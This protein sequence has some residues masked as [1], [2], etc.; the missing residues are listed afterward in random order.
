[1]DAGLLLRSR[2]GAAEA[3]DHVGVLGE[4]GPGLLAVDDPLVALALSLGLERGEVGTGAGLRKA[5]APPV[6]D[7]GNARQIFLL[8]LLIAEGVD[9][10]ADHADAEGERRRRRI[11]LQLL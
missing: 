9:H 11:G 2:I 4:R 8:L 5:L 1:G 3:E 10:G 7:I 6:V